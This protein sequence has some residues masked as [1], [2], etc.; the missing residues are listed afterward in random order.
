MERLDDDVQVDQ[1]LV[2]D[3]RQ[4]GQLIVPEI[5]GALGDYF[6]DFEVVA[7]ELPLHEPIAGEDDYNFKGFID[8]I[9]EFLD[10]M[11]VDIY[12]SRPLCPLFF[13]CCAA[14]APS[15]LSFRH[16]FISFSSL[17]PFRLD[18]PIDDHVFPHKGK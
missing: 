9:S 6:E 5:E 10:V 13:C 2:D 7:V 12:D 8:A 1:K 16:F 18:S 4:Q 3:M 14:R 17:A 11:T 15:S